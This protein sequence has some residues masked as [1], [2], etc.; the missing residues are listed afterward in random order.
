M[1]K[2]IWTAFQGVLSYMWKYALKPGSPISL[3]TK[4]LTWCT[5]WFFSVPL[6]ANE[7]WVTILWRKK[8]TQFELFQNCT[9]VL[10]HVGISYK[11]CWFNGQKCDCRSLYWLHIPVTVTIRKTR[12]TACRIFLPFLLFYPALPIYKVIV[13]PCHHKIGVLGRFDK[14]HLGIHWDSKVLPKMA[15]ACS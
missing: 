7:T 9:A 15:N 4:K 8:V 2:E 11:L 6:H 5:Y 1:L 13:F 10:F 14:C 3:P 12:E